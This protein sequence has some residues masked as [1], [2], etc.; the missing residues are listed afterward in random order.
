MGSREAASEG[1][2][3][4]HT[5]VAAKSTSPDMTTVFHTRLYGIFTDIKNKLRR[6]KLLRTNK[7]FIFL[8]GSFCSRDNVEVSI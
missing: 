6:K 8:G 1:R 2:T 5:E 7:G 3:V 4:L